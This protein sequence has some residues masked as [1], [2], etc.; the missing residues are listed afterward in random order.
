MLGKPLS[1]DEAFF[2]AMTLRA[3]P[4]PSTMASKKVVLSDPSGTMAA[5]VAM[6]G[7]TSPEATRWIASTCCLKQNPLPEELRKR[8]IF[9]DKVTEMANAG[10]PW[11]NNDLAFI[12]AAVISNEGW[13]KELAQAVA[14]RIT[15]LPAILKDA[16]IEKAPNEMKEA[17]TQNAIHNA[18]T[19]EDLIWAFQHCTNTTEPPIMAK[20]FLESPS[21]PVNEKIELYNHFTKAEGLDPRLYFHA[22]LRDVIL[23]TFA[24]I[25][26]PKTFEVAFHAFMEGR[27]NSSIKELTG[28]IDHSLLHSF[29]LNEEL[30]K[31]N[32]FRFADQSFVNLTNIMHSDHDQS[33]KGDD[34][35]EFDPS[36]P[37]FN[38][39][40]W[41]KFQ[42]GLSK[43]GASVTEKRF[44]I[45]MATIMI[46]VGIPTSIALMRTNTT[47]KDLSGNLDVVRQ[48]KAVVQAKGKSE[49]DNKLIDEALTKANSAP[50]SGM[51]PNS[52]SPLSMLKGDEPEMGSKIEESVAKTYQNV[53][54]VPNQK[55]SNPHEKQSC[56]ITKPLV[57]T[58]IS[59][60]E[61]KGKNYSSVGAGG[62]MQLM[63][64][65]WDSLNKRYFGGKYPFY[66]WNSHA[67]VNR[68]FGSV[69]LEEIKEYLDSHRGQWKTDELPLILACYHGGIGNIKQA[70][71]DPLKIKKLMPRTYDY[72]IRGSNLMGHEVKRK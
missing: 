39:H 57:D 68:R 71:F 16:I 23:K 29:E 40:Q 26:N 13:N 28:N 20:K 41:S 54:P 22:Y 44:A 2:V 30:H 46:L 58:V 18:V 55:P 65:T 60:E 59:L 32:A 56:E 42:S 15:I 53:P 34:Q 69:Y 43:S 67:Y 17:M 11:E 37:S 49:Q 51:R 1:D 35:F 3:F 63:P 8:R 38:L 9:V 5:I 50:S 27:D 45:L 52:Y 4:V 25:D 31:R 36:E 6:C 7:K 48:G 10:V 64:K 61:V 66:Q 14:Y 33:E 21:V 24:S 12:I 19:S 47:A 70:N 62:M 72:M